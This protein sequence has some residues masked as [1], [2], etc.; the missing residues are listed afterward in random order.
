MSKFYLTEPKLVKQTGMTCW[1]AAMESWLASQPTSPVAWYM[2]E[3][4]GIV[5]EIRRWSGLEEG[6]GKKPFIHS[7]GGLTKEGSIWVL[8]NAGMEGKGFTNPKLITGRF[9]ETKLRSFGHLYI[10]RIWS[11]GMSHG[12]VAYGIEN[13]ESTTA[14]KIAVMDPRPTHGLIMLDLS[15]L[16]SDADAFIGWLKKS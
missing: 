9:I 15:N 1:A 10:I 7:N 13:P 14:C 11:G 6:L 12:I 5:E 2:K 16:Q 8:E 4:K 3:E